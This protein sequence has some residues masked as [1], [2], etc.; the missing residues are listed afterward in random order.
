MLDEWS[1][2]YYSDEPR[3]KLTG[4]IPDKLYDIV[5]RDSVSDE[6]KVICEISSRLLELRE[7]NSIKPI[8]FIHILARIA[9]ISPSALWV[10]L[11]I[12]SGGSD[13][14]KSLSERGKEMSFSKQA[15]HQKRK[16]DL[17]MLND[18]M[19]ELAETIKSILNVSKS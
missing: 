2:D 19:P 4:F 8:Q 14:E 10:V 12:L 6:T 9:R 3:S 1:D 15:I 5:E 18:K 13:L 17:Q 16:R 11:E 7:Y